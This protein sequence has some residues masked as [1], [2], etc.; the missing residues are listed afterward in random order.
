MAGLR[1]RRSLPPGPR[2]PF[3]YHMLR[4]LVG[5]VP[6]VARWRER[7]GD[8]FTLHVPS[9]GCV[10]AVT[11]PELV[12][13]ALTGDP[14]V[15]E[16]GEGNRPL[17]IAVGPRSLLILD[18]TEHLSQRKL[19]LPPFHGAAL[20][21]YRDLIGRLADEALDRM[22]VGK[23]FGLLPRMQELTLEIIM[24][25]VFGIEDERRLAELRPRLRRLLA[26]ATSPQIYPRYALRAVGGM[27]SWRSY[28][29]AVTEA[30]RL[31]LDEI[32]RRRADPDLESRTDIVALLLRARTEEGEGMSDA[33]MR[34]QLAT[35]VIAGHETT[36]NALSWTFERLV[37]HPDALERLT[38]EAAAENGDA[39]A[40]A[41]VQE[42]MRVRPPVPFVA[43]KL[44][45]SFELDGHVLPA[46]TRVLPLIILIHDRADLYQ[47]PHAF[48]PE[49]FLDARPETYGWLPFG[50][51]IRR[52]IGASFATLEMKE[53]LHRMV[54]RG[55][56]AA[57]SKRSERPFM[58]AI[59]F[60]P[61]RGGRVV[62]ERRAAG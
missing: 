1:T 40:G 59:F 24:Q 43:R 45:R 36:A 12:K 32:A 52:C 51:G 3:V 21:Q 33:A 26:L 15:L 25:V 9:I 13:Q 47:D 56:F 17:E 60:S 6:Y 11:D 57:T 54:R 41:V 10:V 42:A 29:R 18:G 20:D 23:P 5:G 22:P 38:E 46:G 39:Y 8:L 31:L 27:R 58:R 30:D 2:G 4:A 55:D 35:L 62:L 37:R 50:G 16:A 44:T 14:E 61:L 28:R 34:D 49:R 7:Y 53:V 19:L 48:R